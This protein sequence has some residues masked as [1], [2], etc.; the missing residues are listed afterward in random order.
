MVEEGHGH[1]AGDACEGE[2]GS[3]Q[4]RA[5]E[6]DAECGGRAT[7]VATEAGRA[8]GTGIAT[9]AAAAGDGA[10]HQEV[11][12]PVWSIFEAFVADG[13][14]RAHAAGA[15]AVRDIT[16]APDATAN[17]GPCTEGFLH[18]PHILIAS[19]RRVHE[20]RQC[21]LHKS[22][23]MQI[24]T[25]YMTY[26]MTGMWFIFCMKLNITQTRFTRKFPRD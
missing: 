12:C 20:G 15:A 25:K 17:V 16:L 6:R 8:P 1:M 18:S 26:G 23:M 7:V 4:L 22:S 11:V 10:V 19:L 24:N 21:S 14:A 2:V 13:R 9:V 3:L 5:W